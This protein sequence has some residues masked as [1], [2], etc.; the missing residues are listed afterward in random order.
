[1]YFFDVAQSMNCH[2]ASLF[3][4][5][6]SWASA[7]PQSQPDEAVLST[8]AGAKPS[9]PATG[10]GLASS[11]DAATVASYHI[12]DFPCCMELRHSLKLELP[13]PGSPSFRTRLT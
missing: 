11:V 2:A 6:L 8:G 12:A 4:D 9:L 3:F 7:Q 10:L 1:M 13:A 5:A